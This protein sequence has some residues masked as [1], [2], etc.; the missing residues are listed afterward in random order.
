MKNW[1]FS[2]WNDILV[3]LVLAVS[4]WIFM[5]VAFWGGILIGVSQAKNLFGNDA[6][7]KVKEVIK[8]LLK[9]K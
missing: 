1:D 6:S 7:E 5:N 9:S 8:S 3:A 4:C 2:Q